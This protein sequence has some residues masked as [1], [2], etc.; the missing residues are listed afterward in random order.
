MLYSGPADSLSC[1]FTVVQLCC[2]LAR[3]R[4]ASSLGAGCGWC[5]RIPSGSGDSRS[6]VGRNPHSG[7]GNS[8]RSDLGRASATRRAGHRSGAPLLRPTPAY[9]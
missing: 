7:L 8:P 2:T 4:T 1:T 5:V 9:L 3:L 6:R